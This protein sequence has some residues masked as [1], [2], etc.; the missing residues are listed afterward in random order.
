MSR[1]SGKLLDIVPWPLPCTTTAMRVASAA[2][3]KRGGVVRLKSATCNIGTVGMLLVA[4]SVPTVAFS[5]TASAASSSSSYLVGVSEPMTGAEAEAGTEI[6]NG[7]VLAANKIN[8]AGGVLGHQIVLK[9]EDDACDP[10]TSVNAANKLIS[11]GVQAQVGGYCSSAAQPAE[12]IYSR[13]GIPNV[14]VAANSTTLTS[15][16]YK[17]VFL[18]DPGGG[19]QAE[20]ATGFFSKV[21]GTKRLLI[22]DDQSTYAVNVA[23]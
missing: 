10:Q 22:V 14:Q 15:G 13:A 4:L 11:L 12:S 3:V 9:E 6:W 2:H 7:E 8:A 16:G 21:L 5:P 19:L 20:E 23:R 18:I 1:A 17:D